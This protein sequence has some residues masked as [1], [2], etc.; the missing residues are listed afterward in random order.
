MKKLFSLL[1]LAMAG[2]APA[3]AQWNTNA[4]PKCI[5][6]ASGQGDYYA[7]NPKVARTPDKKTW[8]AWKTSRSFDLNGTTRAGEYIAVVERH[9]ARLGG[10]RYRL[11]SC[12]GCKH[13]HEQHDRCQSHE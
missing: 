7:C 8:I 13:Q 1:L 12:A 6:D 3:F 5:F 2:I 9:F 11:G 10:Q 4:T